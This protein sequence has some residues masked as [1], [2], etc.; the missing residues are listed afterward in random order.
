MLKV[1]MFVCFFILL[2]IFSNIV[3]GQRLEVSSLKVIEISLEKKYIEVPIFL[4]SFNLYAREKESI[5]VGD[6]ITIKGTV[7][8]PI[9]PVSNV[10]IGIIKEDVEE[11]CWFCNLFCKGKRFKHFE[12]VEWIGF[13]KSGDFEISVHRNVKFILFDAVDLDRLNVLTLNVL[14]N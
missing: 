12:F 3:N 13:T 6:S 8:Y 9:E 4:G 2:N 11:P 5:I 14:D 10:K 7:L 1:N